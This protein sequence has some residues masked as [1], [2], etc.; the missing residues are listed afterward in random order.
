MPKHQHDP[1]PTEPAESAELK[2]K[3]EFDQA[4]KVLVKTA[5]ESGLTREE[6]MTALTATIRTELKNADTES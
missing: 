3:A 5:L 6:I 4:V 1:F 2:A